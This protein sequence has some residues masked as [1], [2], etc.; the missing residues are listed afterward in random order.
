MAD[1]R[2]EGL[3]HGLDLAEAVVHADRDDLRLLGHHDLELDAIGLL[4]AVDLEVRE[5]L[6][7]HRLI[8]LAA[9]ARAIERLAHLAV[10]ERLDHQVVR[11]AAAGQRDAADR[12]VQLRPGHA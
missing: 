12:A 7:R 11:I 9:Q 8:E 6:R 10:D 4:L 1:H 2:R 3:G 5:R